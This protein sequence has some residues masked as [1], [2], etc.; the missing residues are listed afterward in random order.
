ML[1]AHISANDD[2]FI[3][4]DSDCDGYTSAALLLNYLYDVYPDYVIQHI[5]VG[6]H[7]DKGHGILLDAITPTAKLVIAPDSS[8]SEYE[9][10]QALSEAGIDV[11]VLDHHQS[12]Q[13]S[14]YACVIN[15]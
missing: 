11:L 2:I 8:S 7:S 14:Q 6:F 10:H 9:I 13:V 1:L 12:D 4:V 15:N 3:Q 5:T